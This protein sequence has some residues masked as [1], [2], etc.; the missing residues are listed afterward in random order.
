MYNITIVKDNK[1]GVTQRPI[2][3][4]TLYDILPILMT[5][6]GQYM[7]QITCDNE[8]GYHQMPMES[9]DMSTGR[10]I[11][12]ITE[13]LHNIEMPIAKRPRRKS[14]GKKDEPKRNKG[15]RK[16]SRVRSKEDIPGSGIPITE[17]RERNL[18]GFE[19]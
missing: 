7:L 12:D 10:I 19:G 2:S 1:V 5:G 8:L 17:D 9:L 15:E 11:F 3:K 14:D 4:E 6:Q 16:Q 13:T 18:P